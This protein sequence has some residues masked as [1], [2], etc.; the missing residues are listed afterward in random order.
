MKLG[1]AK[2]IQKLQLSKYFDTAETDVDIAL[3]A[4][5]IDYTD[6]WPSKRVQ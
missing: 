5:H 4:R 6:T 1:L 3:N 2:I